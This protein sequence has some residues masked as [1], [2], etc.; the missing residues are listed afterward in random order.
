MHRPLT[1]LRRLLAGAA[2]DNLADGLRL[3]ALP[4][5]AAATTRSPA[6]VAA[7]FAAELLP[8]LVLPAPAGV[9]VDRWGPRRMVRLVDAGRLLLALVAAVVLAYDASSLVVLGLCGA[10]L[11]ALEVG[12]DTAREAWL[13]VVADDVEAAGGRL[14]TV[15]L[16]ANQLAGP[17][18]GAAL[19]AVSPLV[20][21]L[22]AALC[23]AVGLASTLRMPVGGVAE[24]AE[25]GLRAALR[26]ARTSPPLRRLLAGAATVS[27]LDAAWSSTLVLYVGRELDGGAAGYGVAFVAQA[28]GA[29]LGSALA[30]RVGARSP[31][32][33]AAGCLAVSQL[34]L[35]VAPVVAVGVP[36]LLLNGAAGSLWRVHALA[37][38]Q[39]VVPRALLGR[40]AGLY[41]L[42]AQGVAPLG[43]LAGG[44][45]ASVAGLRAPLLLGVVP[46]ALAAY[47]L[48]E[49]RASVLPALGRLLPRPRSL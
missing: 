19:F 25:R 21:F 29:V 34:W 17:A 10:A 42:T 30:A 3:T 47:A 49:R 31:L 43:A 4:L 39:R 48:R 46:L 44:A 38:R 20:P 24:E 18:L 15:E 8:W 9:L 35:G 40:V 12:A 27:A 41:R 45:L 5:A 33:L 36:A 22:L 32:A 37:V 6:G 23:H 7:V 16:V 13:P 11:G 26:F 1:P 2:A 28:A 14:V